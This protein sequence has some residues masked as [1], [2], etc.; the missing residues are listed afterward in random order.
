M[1]LT[2]DSNVNYVNYVNTDNGYYINNKLDLK[3]LWGSIW[4]P[5][6]AFQKMYLL[7]RGWHYTKNEVFH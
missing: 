7:R 1:L 3:T 4:P 2:Y 6:V 5:S